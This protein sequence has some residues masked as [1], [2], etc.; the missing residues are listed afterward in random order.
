MKKVEENTTEVV[1]TDVKELVPNQEEQT[2]N[3]L[4]ITE[5]DVNY[6]LQVLALFLPEDSRL[7]P[8]Q[9]HLIDM[10]KRNNKIDE[11]N[12]KQPK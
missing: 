1:S 11:N 6:Y 8:L 3:Y 2:V 7:Q 9:K 4:K 10:I 5:D 12:T